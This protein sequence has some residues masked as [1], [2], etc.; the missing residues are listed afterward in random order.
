MN[1]L[2]L[3]RASKS[4][5]RTWVRWL[6]AGLESI[7]HHIEIL[8]A[9]DWMPM[10][11]GK[12]VDKGVSARLIAEAK[13]FDAVH[14]FGYRAA[15]ACAE[16]FRHKFPWVYTA[17]D[18]PK[19]TNH[20][21]IDRL[22]LATMGLCVSKAIY[23]K[24]DE[25]WCTPIKTQRPVVQ[26]FDQLDREAIRKE[27]GL[28]PEDMLVVIDEGFD[29]EGNRLDLDALQRKIQARVPSA[30]LMS[31]L[32]KEVCC[33]SKMVTAA[34][35]TVST[36]PRAGTSCLALEGL[37]A[38]TPALVRDQAGCEDVIDE[39]VTGFRFVNDSELADTIASALQAPLT[40]ESMGTAARVRNLK[41]EQWSDL[42]EQT[43]KFY[44]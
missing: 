2:F 43:V 42:L 29:D 28:L 5:Q 36:D 37:T 39:H 17:H 21:L 41:G 10:P 4:S 1:V 24:L 35:L 18:M 30:R 22:G 3:H 16:A 38:G 25:A 11:T 44:T 13:D 9:D 23:K 40:L 6:A 33:S 31:I 7:G 32:G 14:A 12:Q 19:T 34:D 20:E 15:W 27:A 26:P 8:D